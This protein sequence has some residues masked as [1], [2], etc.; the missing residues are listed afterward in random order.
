CRAG[1]NPGSSGRLWLQY[2]RRCSL[3]RWGGTALLLVAVRRVQEV[4]AVQ[5]APLTST[6]GAGGGGEIMLANDAPTKPAHASSTAAG[7]QTPNAY[8]QARK[9]GSG[10]KFD[11]AGSWFMAAS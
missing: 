8:Q 4:L 1:A 10:E 7:S 2:R 5:K 3:G 11:C 6:T 9:E